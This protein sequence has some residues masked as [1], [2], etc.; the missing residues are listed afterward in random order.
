MKTEA[1]VDTE[2]K[3]KTKTDYELPEEVEMK[4]VAYLKTKVHTQ[5]DTEIKIKAAD[6]I[7]AENKDKTGIG[8]KRKI[9]I[10]AEMKTKH[11]I[12]VDKETAVEVRTQTVYVTMAEM[13]AEKGPKTETE[14]EEATEL[15]FDK[16]NRKRTM[17]KIATKIEAGTKPEL[18]MK[19]ELETDMQ[20]NSQYRSQT[21]MAEQRIGVYKQNQTQINQIQQQKE[22]PQIMLTKYRSQGGTQ[23]Q[24]TTQPRTE[25]YY[26]DQRPPTTTIRHQI[27]HNRQHIPVPTRA[28]CHSVVQ[29]HCSYQYLNTKSFRSQFRNWRDWLFRAKSWQSAGRSS[30]PLVLLT[31]TLLYLLSAAPHV[32]AAC[33][34]ES[35]RA[36]EAICTPDG[37]NCTLRA[38]LLLPDD[39]TY[40]A[41]MRRTMPV[42]HLADQ[43]IRENSLL[44]PQ[45]NFE[46]MTGDVKCD[47][48]Y[49]SI[50][51][52]DGIVKNCAHVVFG[53]VCD[54]ALAAVSR[55]AK[56]FNSNG[57]PVISIGGATDS[58]EDQKTTCADE[59][60]ML[61]RPGVLSFK[62]LSLMIIELM[63]RYNWSNSIA[64]Y[65]RDGQSN[66]VGEHSCY[67]MMKSFGDEMRN[68][69][70]TFAQ[71][72]IV[73]ELRNRTEE[74]VREIGN[75]HTIVIM[76]ADPENI[77]RI[78]L[79]AEELN[80]VDSGE[81]IFINIEMFSHA[82]HNAW[83][84]WYDK[85]DTKENNERAKKAYT[86][87]LNLTP[88]QPDDE[89]YTRV[90]NKIKT[91]A[92]KKYNYTFQENEDV[93]SFV[94]SFFDGVLLYAKALNDSIREDPTVLTRPING[95]DIVRRMWGRSFKGI[96]GNVTIDNNGDRISAYSLL[97][98]NPET[99]SF[100]IVAD[101][102]HNRLDFVPGKEIH[103]AGGRKE[104]PL[105][106]P[107][108]GYD[109]S[110][111]PDNSLPGYAILS[112]I[113]G[114][115]VVLMTVG[116]FFGYRHYKSEAEINSMTWKVSL[117]DLV[118]P[119]L[120]GRGI[121]GSFH[122]LVRHNSQ[123]T[124]M[125]DDLRSLCGDR[126]IFIP[127]GMYRGC[128]VAIKAIENRQINLTRSLMLELKSMKDLQHD[129]LVKF[130]GACLD[131]PKRFLLT[132]YCPKGSLQDILENEQFQLD[133]MIKLS[134]MH[135][136]V[137]GMHFLHNS[138][139]RS[140]G[141]LKSSNCVVDSRFVLKITDFG[142]HTLKRERPEA[143]ENDVED[144]NSHAYWSKLFWTS[145]EL[146]KI[147]NN[148]PPEGTQKGDVY[149]FGIIVH[150]IS[151]RQ[152][153]FYLGKT[154]IEKSPKE[155]IE[156]VKSYPTQIS[157]P[158]RP[159]I[160]DHD[161]YLD[162][163]NLMI[164]CWAEDPIDRPDFNALK[165][166]IRRINKDNETGNIVDNLLKRMELYANNLEELV[167]ERTQDYIEEKKKCEKLLYQLLPQSVAA[168][169]ISGQPVVAET[170]DQVTIYFSD[171]VGFTA[172]SAESTPMQ[173]V[174]FLN[175]LY[176]CFDSIV[177]NFDVYKVETI[178]DAYM[179]VSGLPIRNG[180]QHARE[181]ARLALALLGAVH[182]FRIHHRPQDQLKLRI[183]LHTGACVAGVV[184]LKMPRYC[185]FGDT[186]NT[187]SRMESNGEALRIHISEHTK[188]ALDEF[189]TFITTKRGYV[190]MKGK[191]EMLTY[192]LEG[193]V[194][195]PESPSVP[196]QHLLHGRRSSLK[197]PPQRYSAM[198]QK[199]YSEISEDEQLSPTVI[200]EENSVKK[201]PTLRVKR[202][203]SSSS[204]KLN[205]NEFKPE[206]F[207]Y[208]LDNVKQYNK[209]HTVTLAKPFNG[210]NGDIYSSRSLRE[211]RKDANNELVNLRLPLSGALKNHNNNLANSHRNSS[212][213]LLQSNSNSNL[214]GILQPTS[215]ALARLRLKP[216]PTIS[217]LVSS[218]RADNASLQ[219]G[220]RIKFQVDIKSDEQQDNCI[221]GRAEANTSAQSLPHR[222]TSDD[223]SYNEA[224]RYMPCSVVNND[225]DD[226]EAEDDIELPLNHHL[227]S[228]KARLLESENVHSVVVAKN[229]CDSV[230]NSNNNSYNNIVKANNAKNLHLNSKVVP[231]MD[232][233]NVVNMSAGVTGNVVTVVAPTV[234]SV[235]QPLLGK[236]NS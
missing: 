83:K 28:A 216:S 5:I 222:G 103:W 196:A 207:N 168:Q 108:C 59:F 156:L 180:N 51:A 175:D 52:M 170:F 81:Y 165:S 229:R 123:L 129:H 87:I 17:K 131:P 53:P 184:G 214:S 189:G 126:Q 93:S 178:G 15:F 9:E 127:V 12:E 174:Q 10:K 66:V 138:V 128:E 3:I 217:T 124:L 172:I 146:L 160:D 40:T 26:K 13:R 14:L 141:N 139:I 102:M 173:V 27:V 63:K 193:E 100:E 89:A 219:S 23:A 69:N 38:L 197:H 150:E 135:D 77:R 236:I 122:S 195:K 75:K 177:E 176:T 56:Y 46:W 198:L 4:R 157:T 115:V 191:G 36:C 71:Y 120:G 79:T 107:I 224:N 60:Y 64:F 8:V 144:C 201:T 113:L 47:A 205:G 33:R 133:W 22:K 73:P 185:L 186:V 37:R 153:P 132:E 31:Y 68:L 58:F 112:I 162:I 203:I 111:C 169:L 2:I 114:V 44:S 11:L 99:G 118:C 1:E 232:T 80:M 200:A 215:A 57:T 76:C 137:R 231:P 182:K 67:L 72:S 55:I 45:L 188:L 227:N 218:E 92:T 88:K 32:R 223:E 192:W 154:A 85:N 96:T 211:P 50:K 179:V 164:K 130:Y 70:L 78:M 97:D 134:L 212:A 84:P 230:C 116:F 213:H 65:E 163:N 226:D 221:N 166:I 149:S 171:I 235:A 101:F 140:H 110:L 16:E 119:D 199:Q 104:P 62:S 225:V 95:T 61:V 91:I 35:A 48:A 220:Q 208:Y 148:R 136:I 125:S 106:M 167:E 41:S 86:A 143:V 82:S 206:D 234:G 210:L 155:I 147:G 142:L 24:L 190:P 98:M 21:S 29:P 54:Y 151:T 161:G 34:E 209:E 6:D 74:L 204:P 109:G 194:P 94:I 228:S 105:S 183:G 90:S 152:G 18:E 43:Y 181:I 25:C 187:A 159:Y 49:A 19:T 39:N 20:N 42:L 30:P 7:E 233:P 158:F 117:S 121:R 202:K 145:P